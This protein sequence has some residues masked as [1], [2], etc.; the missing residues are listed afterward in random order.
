MYH[1]SKREMEE[2]TF[3]LQLNNFNLK[4][5]MNTWKLNIFYR[6]IVWGRIILYMIQG[7]KLTLLMNRTFKFS[8]Q[9]TYTETSFRL[10]ANWT[11]KT[12]QSVWNQLEVISG[13]IRDRTKAV[14]VLMQIHVPLKLTRTRNEFLCV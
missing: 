7:R 10:M 4:T 11:G 13:C 6:C 5:P 9:N 1:V 14:E 3:W 12:V 8:C 2:Y